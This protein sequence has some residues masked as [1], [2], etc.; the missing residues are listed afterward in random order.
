MGRVDRVDDERN[1]ALATAVLVE[2]GALA[3]EERD[4]RHVGDD[5]EAG[6]EE[7]RERRG[8]VA[9]PGDPGREG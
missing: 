2:P 8:N 3:R 1:P 5:G 9:A 6:G 7:V 4:R